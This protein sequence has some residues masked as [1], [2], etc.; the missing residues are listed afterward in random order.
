MTI[1]QTLRA[2]GY[3]VAD[4]IP[5]QAVDVIH[6]RDYD[7]AVVRAA[8]YLADLE[9]DDEVWEPDSYCQQCGG[10][11]PGTHACLRRSAGVEPAPPVAPP[12]ESLADWRLEQHRRNWCDLPTVQPGPLPTPDDHPD[13]NR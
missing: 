7:A 1:R 6:G 13:N 10:A 9:E 12:A 2:I 3:F 8:D 5:W 4:Y 11:Y